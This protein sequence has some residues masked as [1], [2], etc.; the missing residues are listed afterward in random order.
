MPTEVLQAP[1]RDLK[2]IVTKVYAFIVKRKLILWTLIVF[3]GLLA[4]PFLLP[5]INKIYAFYFPLSG[6]NSTTCDSEGSSFESFFDSYEPCKWRGLDE[7]IAS[8]NDMNTFHPKITPNFLGGRN[9]FFPIE[10]S[11]GF[12]VVHRFVPQDSEKV[13]VAT[14]YG[15]VW[16]LIVG[17]GDY[18]Q[19]VM[20][21]NKYPDK[22]NLGKHDWVDVPENDNNKWIKRNGRLDSNKE[23][24]VDIVSRPRVDSSI[25][26]VS[27]TISGYINGELQKKDFDFDYNVETPGSANSLM[28]RIGIGLLDPFNEGIETKLIDFSLQRLD[29]LQSTGH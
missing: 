13:N 28:E 22:E 19:I 12:H 11:P 5:Y 24:T 9:I 17:N 3:V 14:N 15:Y 20:Q 21:R 10:M 26:H 23:I 7:M 4:L 2:C 29:G 8:E 25:I 27:A 6:S 18:N 1:K 16:R